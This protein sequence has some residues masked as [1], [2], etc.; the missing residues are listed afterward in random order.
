M[1]ITKVFNYPNLLQNPNAESIQ[2]ILGHRAGGTSNH[3]V[4]IITLEPGKTSSP[5]YHKVSSES[6]L[7][8]EGVAS[9]IVDKKH[10]ELMP[11]ELVLLQPNEVHQILNNGQ[12]N[13]VFLAVC[14]P[15]WCPEDSF[16]IFG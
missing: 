2:E 12:E 15:A 8:L 10:F 13:L 6:Y 11:C 3:S 16:D 14:V 5:H 4:A 1:I 9:M 7:I